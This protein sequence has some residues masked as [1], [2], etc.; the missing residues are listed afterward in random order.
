MTREGRASR[1]LAFT[2]LTACRSAEVRLAQWSEID[3]EQAVW[4]IPAQRMKGGK[5]HRVPLSPLALKILREQQ[6]KDPCWVFPGARPG[7]PISGTALLDEARRIDANVT[8]HGFRSTFRVWAAEK[9]DT[10]REIAEM[11]LAHRGGSRVEMAYQRS[12]LLEHR[13]VLMDKWALL[14][15]KK[16]LSDE[17]RGPSH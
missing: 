8:V 13:R 3:F 7:K 5:A 12:D 10:P 4:T 11:S 16:Q 17:N 14:C 2:I 1:A 6:G 15:A 9:T